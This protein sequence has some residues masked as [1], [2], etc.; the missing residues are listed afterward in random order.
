LIRVCY[1][2]L[3]RKAAPGL[4]W[5]LRA[6]AAPPGGLRAGAAPPGGLRAGVAPPGGLRAG[7]APPGGLRAGA[8]PPGGS[9]SGSS[10]HSPGYTARGRPVD[11]PGGEQV[12]GHGFGQPGARHHRHS[13]SLRHHHDPLRSLSSPHSV[14][15]ACLPARSL[16]A[17][18][19]RALPL[20][21]SLRADCR[22]ALPPAL[23]VRT[24]GA[25][26]RPSR[27]LRLRSSSLCPRAARAQRPGGG[28]ML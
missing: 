21:R 1:K 15:P 27:A 24:A 25:R 16:R 11:L 20:A 4:S 12:H 17:G 3:I 5:G 13:P 7:A 26:S 8:A 22:R 2:S 10:P 28:A 23:P 18:C 19:R 9:Q 6:G 14:L